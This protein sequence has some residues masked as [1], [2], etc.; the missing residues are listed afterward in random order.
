M[1][2]V[3]VLYVSFS[4]SMPMTN[5]THLY[6]NSLMQGILGN[7]GVIVC[8]FLTESFSH[9][10]KL[11]MEH[12]ENTVIE[13][14]VH[15][16]N[17][18]ALCTALMSIDFINNSTPLIIADSETT[19]LE[20]LVNAKKCFFLSKADCVV[21]FTDRAKITTHNVSFSDGFVSMMSSLSHVGFPALDLCFLRAGSDFV[22]AAKDVLMKGK[23]KGS[24]FYICDA[25]N[26]IILQGKSV[27][28]LKAL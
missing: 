10:H 13:I 5:R 8:T 18:G 22:S 15:K 17:H 7:T 21:T 24:T 23:P 3:N 9:M 16:N 14:G 26:E 6:E 12:F 2:D 19:S 27:V 20:M 1:C 28:G 11:K 25:I 4:N